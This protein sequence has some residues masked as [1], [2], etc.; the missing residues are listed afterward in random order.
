M[1]QLS[2][3]FKTFGKQKVL[4]NFSYQFPQIGGVL[5][6]GPSGRGK[7]TLLNIIA[8]IEMM[9]EGEY[10]FNGQK[11]LDYKILYQYIAY[12]TQ[13]VYLVDYLTIEENLNLSCEKKDEINKWCTHFGINHLLNQYPNEISGGE[14]QRVALIQGICSSKK[15]F[16]LDE[17][18]ANL[19]EDNKIKLFEILQELSASLLIIC[20]SHDEISL[21]Y[22]NEI[23]D[24]YHL[25]QYQKDFVN[26]QHKL[27]L[28]K[29]VIKNNCNLFPYICL[30]KRKEE[31]RTG[32]YLTIIFCVCMLLLCFSLNPEE[33]IIN[34][35][36][37]VYHLNYLKVA[38]PLEHN[39]ILENIKKEYAIESIVF[40]YDR[41]A[42]YIDFL[43]GEE[44]VNLPSLP[45]S[46][47]LL[48]RTLPLG[49][50]FLGY[51]HLEAGSYFTETY[52]IMMSKQKALEY[53][54]NVAS[55]IGQ[56]MMIT[57]PKGEEEF[58][59]TGVFKPFT[60]EL[61][62]YLTYGY[63]IENINSTIF[64]NNSYTQKY[65][66]DEK[67]SLSEKSTYPNRR[68]TIYFNST[69]EVKRFYDRYKDN[70]FDIKND[71]PLYIQPIEYSYGNTIT[72]F[73]SASFFLIPICVL[74]FILTI[75]FY[76]VSKYNQMFQTKKNFSVY[77]YYGYPWKKVYHA[78]CEYFVKQIVC[79]IF[80]SLVGTLFISW[81][82]NALNQK[83]SFLHF[84]LFFVDLRLLISIAL[85][86]QLI[87][88]VSICL[89]LQSFKK[90][91]WYD[92]LRIGR[93]LL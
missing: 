85:L 66:D 59:I 7:T 52:Q 43:E 88:S 56:K 61:L 74:A 70:G 8:G 72:M 40:D 5:L 15:V 60:D 28:S 76:V 6:F 4:K 22:F 58:E 38:V 49:N 83:L 18:T 64:F 30:R 92:N 86:L 20:V 87:L 63:D 57:T 10:L 16:L 11:V 23:I 42:D 65:L 31:K 68:Y 13:D 3:V 12:I 37:D 82:V 45:Y 33:K 79:Y 39:N 46:D 25:D 32:K 35:L 47:S 48:Y 78:Y 41:G 21:N 62:P 27:S 53:S 71:Y 26:V 19:D 24:F 84:P 89:M 50:C 55:L 77:N 81:S 36:F 2:H 69:K 34:S 14:K 29:K 93:D 51:E 80:L 1:I 54:D 73:I 17:P 90:D 91:K 75:F 9:D 44:N 67:L